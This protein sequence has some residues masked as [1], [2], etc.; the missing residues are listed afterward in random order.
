MNL[1]EMAHHDGS[2]RFLDCPQPNFGSKVTVFLLEPGSRPSARSFTRYM[3]EG[4]ARYAEGAIDRIDAEGCWWRFDL[5][6]SSPSFS[7]RFGL[8][9]AGVTSHV[10]GEGVHSYEPTDAAD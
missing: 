7:Y 4:E 3:N 1:V 6:Y 9:R 8:L 2:P 10:N 5:T